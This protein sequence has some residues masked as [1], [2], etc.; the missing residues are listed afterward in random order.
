[1]QGYENFGILDPSQ[2]SV[3]LVDGKTF[4]PVQNITFGGSLITNVVYLK[5]FKALALATNDKHL[6]FYD[7]DD[8]K[9]LKR[10]SVQEAQVYLSVS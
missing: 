1:L 7:I 5:E 10:F 4:K 3:A 2:K 8:K 6:N 9:L